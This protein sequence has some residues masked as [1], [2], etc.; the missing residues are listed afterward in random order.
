MAIKALTDDERNLFNAH[1][2]TH[3]DVELLHEQACTIMGETAMAMVAL[4]PDGRHRALMVT[5]LQ[6]A[7]A[8][9]NAGIA[10]D[11]IFVTTA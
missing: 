10:C 4:V 9:A 11:T 6:Q 2:L 3:E 8:W 1:Y 5:A 7:L